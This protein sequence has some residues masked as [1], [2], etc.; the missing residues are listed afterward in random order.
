MG[1][2]LL[3]ETIE[4]INRPKADASVGVP[5]EAQNGRGEVRFEDSG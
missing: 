3:L 1:T 4:M 5:Q 2:A